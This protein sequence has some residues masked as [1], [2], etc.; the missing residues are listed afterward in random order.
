[1]ELKF[2][3]YNPGGNAT[4]LIIDP[5]PRKRYSEIA[6][7]IMTDAFLCAEQVGFL[8]KAEHPKALAR[9]QMMGG[10][11]CGNASRSLAAWIAM[12][13]MESGKI[14]SIEGDKK[15]VIIEVS[16]CRGILTA[17]V[18]NQRCG[19]R[20]NVELEMPLP[21]NIY[22][23]RND[24]LGDY[25]IVVYEGILHVILWNKTAAD[26][27]VHIVQDFLEKEELETDCFGILFYNS[28]TSHMT[29]V[30][31][32]RAVGSLTW[33]KSCGSGTIALVSALA[34]KEGRS[35]KNM[36][37]H[38]PGGELFASIDW[39]GGIIAA[40]LAGDIDITAAGTIYI[41]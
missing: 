32:V 12:G 7:K 17:V 35:I 14:H 13:G 20:C 40:K 19:Y 30:V 41:D 2:V 6:A 16:G 24:Q 9:L 18:H 11:F 26:S 15:E 28:S 33:E 34:Q 36:Q 22:H 25:S 21:L 29:P 31:Y 27:Y 5:L 38:Q 1:M 39:N 3:K 23:G 37:I 10:E 4:I 8:E